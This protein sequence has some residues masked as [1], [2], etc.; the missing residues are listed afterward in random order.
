V[1]RL[2]VDEMVCG[3]V[4]WLRLDSV[5]WFVGSLADRRTVGPSKWAGFFSG[6]AV[7][8]L[9]GLFHS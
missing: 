1:I 4:G 9:N 3:L 6:C 8:W 5:G 7:G 2:L